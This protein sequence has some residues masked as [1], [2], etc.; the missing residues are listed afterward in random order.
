MK[1]KVETDELTNKAI[2]WLLRVTLDED[3]IRM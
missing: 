2:R 3:G 1:L